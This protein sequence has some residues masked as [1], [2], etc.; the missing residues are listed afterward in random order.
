MTALLALAQFLPTALQLGIAAKPLIETVLGKSSAVTDLERY[1]HATL[2]ALPALI[3]TGI[4]IAGLVSHT[5]EQVSAMLA[6]KRGPT[7]LEWKEQADR[8]NALET[9][10][11]AARNTTAG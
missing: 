4:D 8:I 1:A 11:Q 7:D 5:Q 6:E 3:D 9:E 10:W 2:Q